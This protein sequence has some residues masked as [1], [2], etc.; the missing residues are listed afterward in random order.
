MDYCVSEEFETID[1]ILDLKPLLKTTKSE[2]IYNLLVQILTEYE[3][4]IKR[5]NSV[6]TDGAAA[7][8]GSKKGVVS[9]L[10]NDN[11]DIIAI[12]SIIH[13]EALCGKLGI[14]SAKPFADFVMHVVNKCTAAGAL[15]HRL[16]KEFLEEN[17]AEINDLPKMA[18]V[19]W[20][21]CEKVFSAFNS[22]FNMIKEFL[23][24]QG[25]SIE[26]L[27]NL[28]FQEELCF[29]TDLTKHLAS[30]NRSLQGI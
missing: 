16:L 26:K 18:Q 10:K 17:E 19:R 7:M 12:K 14:K 8:T 27:N 29:F 3:I 30:F 11:P 1:H 4:P 25:V 22:S 24:E 15:G 13:Q 28:K 9:K 5:I 6:T 21:S 2:D 20:L 23:K